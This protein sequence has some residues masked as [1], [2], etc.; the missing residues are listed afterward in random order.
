[1]TEK[2][3]QTLG[4]EFVEKYTHDEYHTNRYKYGVLQLEF[5]YLNETLM[6]AGLTIT[7]QVNIPIGLTDLMALMSI[8]S[9]SEENN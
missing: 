3:I 6:D 1:M 8:F 9:K 7:E 2:Q 4:F 5:T